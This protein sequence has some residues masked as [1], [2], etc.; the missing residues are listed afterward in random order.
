MVGVATLC[1]DIPN[2]VDASPPKGS[3]ETSETSQQ[4]HPYN[5]LANSAASVRK[6]PS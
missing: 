1:A 5:A 3:P 6:K 2:I 4:T